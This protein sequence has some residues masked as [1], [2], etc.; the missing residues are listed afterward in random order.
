MEAR[1]KYTILIS[2]AATVFVLILL[3]EVADRGRQV[4]RSFNELREKMAMLLPP[5]VV[6]EKKADLI[7]QKERL[8]SLLAGRKSAFKHDEGGVFEFLSASARGSNIRLRSVTPGTPQELDQVT[9]IPFTLEIEGPYH[10]LAEFLNAVETG[11]FLVSIRKMTL[12]REGA[13]TALRGSVTGVAY[14]Q[15]RKAPE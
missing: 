6:Q 12:T 5:E 14:V 2:G 10:S 11:E 1:R 7:Q 13:P 9:Q 4:L 3:T 15:S 8:T